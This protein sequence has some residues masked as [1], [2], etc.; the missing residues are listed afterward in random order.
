M[1]LPLNQKTN[2]LSIAFC[3]PPSAP[4][5]VP[6]EFIMLTSGGSPTCTAAPAAVRPLRKCRRETRERLA[7]TCDISPS[8]PG[9]LTGAY[10]RDYHFF[11]FEVGPAK[12][13]QHTSDHRPVGGGFRAPGHIP[14]IL[15]DD[16]LLALRTGRQNGAEFLRGCEGGVRQSCDLTGGVEVQLDGRHLLVGAALPF[17]KGL[18]ERELELLAAGADGV[19]LF[20]AEA[21]RVDEAVAARAHLL[22]G[23]HREALPVGN[24]LGLAHG[25]EVRVDARRRIGNVLAQELFANEQPPGGGRSV[26]GLRSQGEEQRLPEQ[27]RAVGIS[28]E[29][30]PLVIGRRWL[31]AVNAGEV[32]VGKA[33]GG[34]EQ[35][36]KV[37]VAPNEIGDEAAGLLRHGDSG[38]RGEVGK[39]AALAGGG[40]DAVEAEPLGDELV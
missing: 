22:G 40:Q 2:R 5:A 31:D 7:I 20:E 4:Y 29:G 39:R 15:L 13:F 25:R 12:L 30:N 37:A 16:A 34:R 8:L 24:G 9:K 33:V 21:D 36:G 14:E 6:S 27:S 3:G 18:A 23:V 35:L 10:H 19:E 32:A 28:R 26:V 17:A 11:E 38:V 1:P